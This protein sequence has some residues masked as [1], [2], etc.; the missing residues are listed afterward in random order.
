MKNSEISRQLQHIKALLDKTDQACASN[1]EIQSHWAKYICIL[2]AGLLENALKEVYGCYARSQVSEPVARFVDS[3]LNSV[4]NPKT[5]L[6]LE[7]AGAFKEAWVSELTEFVDE[8]GRKEAIDS[9]MN[10]RHLIAHGKV[11]NS[12][13]SLSQVKAYLRRAVEVIDFIEQQTER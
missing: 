2:S 6:F 11:Q 9:I 3:R 5:K 7:T 4:R 10:Q 13:L 1:P 8:D 12:S